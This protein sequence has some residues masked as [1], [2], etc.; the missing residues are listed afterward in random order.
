MLDSDLSRLYEAQKDYAAAR[1]TLEDAL[2]VIPGDK[3]LNGALARLL[4]RHFRTEGQ[5]AEACWRRSFTEGDTNYTSQFWFARR[6]YLNDKVD[7]SLAKY[8]K[9]K[10]VHLPRALKVKI[11]GRI[12]DDGGDLKVFKGVVSRLEDDYAL[13]TPFGQQRQVMLHCSEVAEERWK[14]LRRNDAVNFTIGF[15]YLGP[16]AVLA[17]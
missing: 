12:R 8:A 2:R 9:L 10:L 13:L 3:T 14:M 7:E 5:E 4:D 15:N 17:G 6:L 11:S 1:K 16:A